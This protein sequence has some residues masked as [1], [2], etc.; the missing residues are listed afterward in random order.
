MGIFELPEG[1]K[2][3][4]KV[5]LQQDKKKMILL[6]GGALVIAVLLFL[7]GIRV[8]PLGFSIS[9]ANGGLLRVLG[10]ALLLFVLMALY[11]VGHELIHGVC[12]RRYT[13]VKAKYGFTGAYAFAGSDAYFTKRQ[14]I[15]VA[16]APVVAFGVVFL[17]CNLLLPER[18]FWVVYFLQIINLSGAVGDYYVTFLMGRLPADV[19]VKDSGVAMAMY[20]RAG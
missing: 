18:W 4:L 14:Y 10:G 12:I 15:I 7:L 11:M 8:V 6:N 20:S 19:L 13:G 5:D 17:L 9:A 1:Y 3:I 16:L 2:E